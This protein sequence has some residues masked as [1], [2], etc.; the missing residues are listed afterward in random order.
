MDDSKVAELYTA[1]RGASQCYVLEKGSFNIALGSLDLEVSVEE[2]SAA[3]ESLG[4]AAG[5][6]VSVEEFECVLVTLGYISEAVT[7]TKKALH[8][9]PKH[10]SPIAGSQKK[11][12]GCGWRSSSKRFA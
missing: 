11:G 8:E 2:Q 1:M 9:D 5:S 12:N 4:L 7:K 10:I 6:P 3:W